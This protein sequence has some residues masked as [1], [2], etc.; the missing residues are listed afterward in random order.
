SV[1]ESVDATQTRLPELCSRLDKESELRNLIRLQGEG[2]SRGIEVYRGRVDIR[3]RPESSRR[4]CT[5]T[6]ARGR[7]LSDDHTGSDRSAR[8]FAS[9]PDDRYQPD[10]NDS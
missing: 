4:V 2:D 10:R 9:T 8:G 1:S 6:L 7:R 5:R 3:E